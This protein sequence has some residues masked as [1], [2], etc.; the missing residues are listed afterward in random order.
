M[1]DEAARSRIANRAVRSV[2]TVAAL[3]SRSL[4]ADH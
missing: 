2:T 4:A 3:D 1:I